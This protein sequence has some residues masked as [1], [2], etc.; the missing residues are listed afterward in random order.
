MLTPVTDDDRALLRRLKQ[1]EV[2]E[3][4]WRR[5]R[6]PRFHRKFFALV[7][8]A[9]SHSDSPS[10]ECFLDT[11]KILA[12]HYDNVVLPDG[13]VWMRPKSISFANM[14]EDEFDAFYSACLDAILQHIMPG[15]DPGEVE[16]MLASYA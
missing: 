11:L 2:I 16:Y 8:M 4:E 6:N 5:P 13:K 9:Y 1:G 15:A 14:S 7:N 10:R 12:G 3:V